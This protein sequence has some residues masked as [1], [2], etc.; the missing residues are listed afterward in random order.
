LTVPQVRVLL[1]VTLPARPRDAETT[2]AL[3][4]EIQRRNYAAARS[5]RKRTLRRL[6]DSS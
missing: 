2:L 3:V 6:L 5:H 1:A 4:L